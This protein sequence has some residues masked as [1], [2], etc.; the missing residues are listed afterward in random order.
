MA[1]PNDGIT[2]TLYVT[3][4]SEVVDGFCAELPERIKETATFAGLRSIRV[5]RHDTEVGLF[6]MDSEAAFG[7]YMDWRVKSG[8]LEGLKKI[9]VAPPQ[10]DIWPTLA[11]KA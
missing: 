3:L 7:A 2:V 10:V 11:A 6:L 9:V 1:N 4:K 5:V 8:S